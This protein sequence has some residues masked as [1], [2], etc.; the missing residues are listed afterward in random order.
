VSPD[1]TKI[2]ISMNDDPEREITR[3]YDVSPDGERFL[4]LG[5]PARVSNDPSAGLTRFE[6]VLNWAKE[7][8]PVR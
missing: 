2:A 3:T 7:L 1:G 6:S 5:A 8:Q 4:M